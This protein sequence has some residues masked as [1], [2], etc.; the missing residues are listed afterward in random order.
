MLFDNNPFDTRRKLVCEA[1]GIKEPPAP[2]IPTV[3]NNAHDKDGIF[4]HTEID[5]VVLVD[6][7]RQ[8]S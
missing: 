7:G 4:A 8:K 2:F 5:N 6:N 1:P 3:T